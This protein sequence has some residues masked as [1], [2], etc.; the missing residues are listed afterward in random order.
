MV[1][2]MVY[3][4]HQDGINAPHSFMAFTLRHIS[5]G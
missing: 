2:S 3:K 5:G 4:I 1:F